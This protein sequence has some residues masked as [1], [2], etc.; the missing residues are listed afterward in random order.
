MRLAVACESG[1]VGVWLLL[2]LL[3]LGDGVGN[4]DVAVLVVVCGGEVTVIGDDV[5]IRSSSLRP[6]PFP[7]PSTTSTQ[8]LIPSMGT[9]E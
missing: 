8:T 3:L 5:L 2:L 7:P 4:M 9:P 6:S 1:E